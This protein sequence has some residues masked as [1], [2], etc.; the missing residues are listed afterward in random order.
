MKRY[1]FLIFALLIA[2]PSFS[3][4]IY[5][6]QDS[7]V[8]FSLEFSQL[9]KITFDNENLYIHLND[10]SVT[11]YSMYYYTEIANNYGISSSVEELEQKEQL[12]NFVSSDYIE[13]NST[14]G[15]VVEIFSVCGAKV[16][17]RRLSDDNGTISIST[18]PK[19]IYILRANDRT[20]KFLK[21]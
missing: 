11:P 8:K 1:C 15:T 20:S 17:T 3:Q 10:G 13:I 2:A 16:A 18:L 14:A 21:R 9:Q 6:K 4:E 5:L 7:E 19:G 12:L